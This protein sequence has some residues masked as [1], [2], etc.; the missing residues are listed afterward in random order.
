M[1]VWKVGLLGLVL[2]LGAARAQEPEPLGDE[3]QVNSYTTD[4]QAGPEVGMGDDGE[5]VV[6][7]DSKDGQDGDLTGVFGQRFTRSGVPIGSEF[8]ANTHTTGRQNRSSVGVT[9]NGSFV[10]SWDSTDGQ[11]GD[12]YGVIAR[13]YD[14]DGLAL[15]GEFVVNTYSTNRQLSNR[16]S[17][18]PDGSFVVVWNSFG[19][20]GDDFGVFGQRFDA[21]GN[22]AGSEF[23]VNT[24]TTDFQGVGTVASAA[25]GGFLV[26]WVSAADQDGDLTGIFAQRF[27]AGGSPIGSEF[28]VNTY[29]TGLQRGPAATF[30]PTGEFVIVWNSRLSSPTSYEVRGRRFDANGLAQGDEFEVNTYTDGAQ[31]VGSIA[32]GSFVVVYESYG[33][34]G[35]SGGIFGQRFSASG[36]RLGGE[37]QI[38]TYTTLTQRDPVIAT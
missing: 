18:A 14:S 33:P 22:P 20:D 30:A 28:Q 35:D 27:G 24:Y 23:Q 38:N 21:A 10:V 16:V 4:Y 11:D 26:V 17:I 12:F 34:D 31:R 25:N 29:T 3:F 9:P 1:K 7:W 15:G 19:Q 5:F 2:C 13:R 6:V 8:Q 36:D 37:F 32:Q